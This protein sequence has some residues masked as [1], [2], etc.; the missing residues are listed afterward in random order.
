MSCCIERTEDGPDVVPPQEEPDIIRDT[1]KLKIGCSIVV[2]VGVVII[3]AAYVLYSVYGYPDPDPDHV[4]A[5]ASLVT[6]INKHREE[7]IH[8]HPDPNTR[9][10][11]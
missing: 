11:L 3:I 2:A 8:Y 9:H 5:I 6:P 10:G 1:R 7:G 4:N